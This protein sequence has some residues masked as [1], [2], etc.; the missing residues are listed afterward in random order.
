MKKTSVF[1]VKITRF[2]DGELQDYDDLLAV[3]EPMEIR[4]DYTDGQQWFTRSIAV[5]MR[6]PGHDFELALGF[7]FTEGIIREMAQV[8]GVRY[9]TEQGHAENRENIVRV[10]LRE[11]VRPDIGKLQRNFYT[12]SSCGVCGKQSMEQVRQ[13]CPV[14]R[15]SS[16]VIHDHT[17]VR[18]PELLRRA[19]DVFR[20]TGSIHAAAFFS[21][22]GK[23]LMLR[24]DVG[25]HNALDKLIGAALSGK[26]Q[27]PDPVN[28][29]LVLSGRASF[30]L[31]QKAAMAGI[32]IV[33]AVG[34]PS[35][36]AVETAGQFD[37]TLVGFLREDRYNIYYDNQRILQK[38]TTS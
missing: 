27:L 7:L 4:L 33:C 5:T 36:L 11:D 29:V 32:P 34:A 6:T 21:G 10:Y 22:A 19:Q 18:L 15:V 1:P 28:S 30:E 13:V 17:M 12:S 16:L 2:R 38:I 20:F 31:L 26:N 24:E 8:K 35:S 37:I 14:H 9:C 23:L 3:E 25:R